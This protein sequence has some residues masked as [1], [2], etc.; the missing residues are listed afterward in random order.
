MSN[1]NFLNDE[2]VNNQLH[3]S[4]NKDIEVTLDSKLVNSIYTHNLDTLIE[5]NPIRIRINL[6][7][8]I[9][10]IG[11][12]KTRRFNPTSRQKFS[13]KCDLLES[14]QDSSDFKI[15]FNEDTEVKKEISEGYY[16]GTKA[17]NLNALSGIQADAKVM[18]VLCFGN[19]FL[20]EDSL[21]KEIASEDIEK[22][23][24]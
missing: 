9:M 17:W 7:K 22:R 23:D 20:A 13:D 4:K 2:Y 16:G 19:E 8:L 5:E 6:F 21:A 12:I 24:Q 1:D 3:L 10:A 11:S 15:I 14:I 18:K